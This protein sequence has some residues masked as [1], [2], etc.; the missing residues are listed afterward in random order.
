[1]KRIIAV[2][3]TAL[4]LTAAMTGCA[5]PK[6]EAVENAG[7][8]TEANTGR[9]A[10]E[11]PLILRTPSATWYLS[12]EDMDALGEDA[13]FEGLYGIIDDMEADFQD[14]RKALAGYI[15]EDV[16][17]VDVY[18]D[19]GNRAAI[20]EMAG[21][22]YNPSG[23][24]IKIFDGWSMGGATLLHEYVH[25]LTVRCSKSPVDYSFWAEGM[26]AYISVYACKNRMA[27][28][29]N[30][31][32][33]LNELPPAMREQAWDKEEDCLDPKLVYMGWGAVMA[34]GMGMGQTYYALRHE[35]IVRTEQIQREL[36]PEDLSFYE[37]AGMIA[38]LVETYGRDL[39]YE[40]WN[41][42]P[43]QTEPIYGKSFHELY[44]SWAAWNDAQCDALGF[45]LS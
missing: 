32:L 4:L 11:Y 1:M 41:T 23:N 39:V 14:A 30:F 34:R 35:M 22:Y 16:P 6:G 44:E 5:K 3:L 2:L 38:Y 21:A 33:D 43:T 40:N 26:A 29:V 9:D 7:Y 27:R 37:A 15:F 42:D 36:K 20:S 18:T 31:G 45:T 28:S 17:P 12:K 10:G 19:F 13:Y 8:K 25:Y 24:F